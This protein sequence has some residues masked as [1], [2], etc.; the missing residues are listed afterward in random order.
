MGGVSFATVPGTDGKYVADS[1]GNIYGPRRQLRPFKYRGSADNSP[2]DEHL[3]VGIHYPC[4]QKKRFVHRLVFES[5][6]GEIPVEM[7]VRHY[8][9]DP[10]NNRLSNLVLGTYKDNSADAARHGTQSAGERHGA[11]KLTAAQVSDIRARYSAGGVS[12]RELAREYGVTRYPI[13]AIV[14]G[15]TWKDVA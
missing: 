6:S 12:Q 4:G 10:T 9:G 7:V 3:G 15:K 8:D 5:F 2:G 14:A 1:E 11:A 13:C